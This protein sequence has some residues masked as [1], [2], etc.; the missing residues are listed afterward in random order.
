MSLPL[1][2]ASH[3]EQFRELIRDNLL[4]QPNARIVNEYP[5]VAGNLY[6]RVLQDVD[7]HPDAA[8]IL[9]ISHSPDEGRKI[10]EKIRQASPELYIIAAD[11]SGD[12]EAVVSTVRAG[13]NDY[14]IL[15]MRRS[16]FRDAVT[17][18]EKAPRKSA[19]TGS[20][21]GRVYTFLGAKGG[22]GTTTLAVNFASVLAQRK[23]QSVLVDLDG[24]GNDCVMQ[25]G[26]SPQYTLLEVGENVTRMDKALFEGFVTRD[27]LGFFVV[28]PPDSLE[29]R[30]Y[31]TDEMF[32]E[33]GT[34]L[35]E[36]YESVV[37][38]AGRLVN[39]DVVLAALQASTTIFLV[40]SQEYPTIRN[41]QRYIAFLMR[42]GF[43]QDQIKVVVNQYTK[44]TNAHLATLEQIHQT[45]NLPVFYGIPS[46]PAV[47]AS[48]NKARPIVADRQ[49]APEFDKAFRAFV[50]KA[51]G[52]KK[53]Q[54]QTAAAVR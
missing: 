19:S 5:D 23:Q 32:R 47:T 10:L 26:S 54:P 31:M 36:K 30:G 49:A 6:I 29:Q 18:L 43:N 17:R 27:P 44:R 35:V 42:M 2:I 28:G 8:L 37:I 14:L 41:A 24:V 16:D 13:A 45:L 52:A 11:Y 21:L 7:H 9:D 4:N 38:D 51:T 3:D 53:A 22:V 39:D 50:D 1:L 12:G 46:T 20:R 33:F 40:M 34:F 25:L 15:P 48:I